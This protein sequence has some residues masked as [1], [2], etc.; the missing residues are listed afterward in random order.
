MILS[1]C[2]QRFV[3]SAAPPADVEALA[4]RLIQAHTIPEKAA[5]D[6]V[7][8]AA[9]ALEKIKGVRPL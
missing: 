4:A 2:R 9:A 8:V 5:A 3:F 7:H 1:N 6:A